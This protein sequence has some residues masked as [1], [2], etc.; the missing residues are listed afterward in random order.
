M[1]RALVSARGLK[2]EVYSCAERLFR[3]VRV[4]A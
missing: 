2:N 4:A 3:L 1:C